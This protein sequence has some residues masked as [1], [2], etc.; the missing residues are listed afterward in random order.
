M[1]SLHGPAIGQKSAVRG[2]V[3]RSSLIVRNV[4]E[5]QRTAP[6]ASKGAALAGVMAKVK[7]V[8]GKPADADLSAKDAY[9]GVAYS[10]RDELIEKFNKTH[11]HWAVSLYLP[12][13]SIE[14]R[15]TTN[16]TN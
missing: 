1:R 7:S 11:A 15:S 9:S 8:L 12:S 10:V 6:S 4:A 2:N 16:A 13:N 3:G 14:P 5:V